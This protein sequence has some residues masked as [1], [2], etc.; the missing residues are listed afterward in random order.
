MFYE[1][2][3]TDADLGPGVESIEDLGVDTEAM[4]ESGTRVRLDRLQ[5]AIQARTQCSRMA[6]HSCRSALAEA[7]LIDAPMCCQGS[8][9]RCW[10]TSDGPLVEGTLLLG[11]AVRRG[12]R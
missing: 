10:Q 2:D 9:P 12:C 3:L 8:T 11:Q 1:C 4:F 6:T 5:N 7:L